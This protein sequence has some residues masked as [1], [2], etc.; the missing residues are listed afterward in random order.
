MTMKGEKDK[1]RITVEYFSASLSSIGRISR[2]EISK[3]IEGLKNTIKQIYLI[4]ISRTFHSITAIYTF[5][6][7]S[8]GTLL[9][10]DLIFHCQTNLNEFKESK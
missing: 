5:F 1:S 10:T 9:T 6:P 4:D 2:Q 8:H 7:S 3:D